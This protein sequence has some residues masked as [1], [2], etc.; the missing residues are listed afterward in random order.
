MTE[1]NQP[2]TGGGYALLL[3]TAIATLVSVAVMVALKRAPIVAALVGWKWLTAGADREG[4]LSYF[5]L[6]VLPQFFVMGPPFSLL[7]ALACALHFAKRPS[8]FSRRT[9]LVWL[10]AVAGAT[11]GWPVACTC[12]SLQGL[13]ESGDAPVK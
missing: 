12:I 6:H 2:T 1:Q 3:A 9:K 7:V 11:A 4:G 8:H 5:L 13:A 10:L